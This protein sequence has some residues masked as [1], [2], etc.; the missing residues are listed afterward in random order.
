MTLR[1]RISHRS[2]SLLLLSLGLD[3]ILQGH[4]IPCAINASSARVLGSSLSSHI[5]REDMCSRRKT[6]ARTMTTTVVFLQSSAHSRHISYIPPMHR[7]PIVSLNW[8]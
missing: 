5:T 3:V 4:V 1:V 8:Y 6:R 2:F 7:S